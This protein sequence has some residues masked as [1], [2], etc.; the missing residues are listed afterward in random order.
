MPVLVINLFINQDRIG[1][2]KASWIACKL[3]ALVSK[4]PGTLG[5]SE[6]HSHRDTGDTSEI[7]WGPTVYSTIG[8]ERD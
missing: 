8:T 1:N 6:F 5:I 7:T 4:A 2:K 3:S